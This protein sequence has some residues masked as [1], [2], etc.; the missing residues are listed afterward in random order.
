MGALDLFPAST[1]RQALVDTTRVLAQAG[2]ATAAL[3]ARLLVMEATGLSLEALLREP[4]RGIHAKARARLARMLE[5]RR[6]REPLA[7]IIGRRA[8]WT[9][10]LAVGPDVLVPRPESETVVEAVLEAVGCREEAYRILDLGTGSGCLVL[11]LLSELPRAWGLG[12]D[13]SEGALALAR[14][15]AAQLGLAARCAFLRGNW[16]AAVKGQFDIVV[17]NPPYIPEREIEA[18]AP[19][20]RRYEPRLALDGGVDGLDAYRQLLG[21]MNKIVARSGLVALEV[22]DG[23]AGAVENLLD[24]TGFCALGRK[25]D[26]AGKLRVVLA[27]Q[28]TGRR[29]AKKIC[30]K[31]SV[32]RLVFTEGS[33]VASPLRR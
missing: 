25:P 6:A 9:F 26:L 8:F 16:L 5:R 21:G 11:A 12:L 30:W 17:C 18:L 31:G 3:D 33:N 22:G 28:G 20:I 14:D 24:A 29:E 1:C 10:E 19:E 7:Y 27:R 15:N 4:D 23:Q 32:K 13:A 2:V